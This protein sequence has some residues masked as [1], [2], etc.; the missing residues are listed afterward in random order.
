MN[1]DLFD[2]LIIDDK[3][4]KGIVDYVTNKQ[5]M[6]FDFTNVDSC[7]ITLLVIL[8]K[9]TSP[10]ERFSIFAATNF[11]LVNL[12]N[13]SVLNRKN[14]KVKGKKVN[15]HEVQIETNRIKASPSKD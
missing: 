1:E 7:A 11:P 6:F 3:E 5:I 10:D 8:W 2:K 4:Y 13:V 15:S 14:V 12:G 9:T